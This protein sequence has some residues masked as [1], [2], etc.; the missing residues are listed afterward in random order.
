MTV[1]RVLAAIG[2]AVVLAAVGAGLYVAGAPSE[3]RLMRLDEQRV[4]DLR[5]LAGA[6]ELYRNA[7]GELPRSLADTVKPQR[8]WRLP[9]DPE[10][11][12]P[13]EYEVIDTRSYRLCAQFARRS[14]DSPGMSFWKHDAGM[15]CFDVP[16]S[17]RK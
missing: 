4:L 7:E 16:V 3:A 14:R 12:D 10:T 9:V 8:V 11:G 1:S 5:S 6:I 2:S 17:A 13:Y 15:Q